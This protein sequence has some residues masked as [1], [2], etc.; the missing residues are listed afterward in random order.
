MALAKFD[1]LKAL[2]H[3]R[4]K[5]L[6][7]E[8]ISSQRCVRLLCGCNQYVNTTMAE[9]LKCTESV[10]P[11][12]IRRLY[13]TVWHYSMPHDPSL[14]D[15]NTHPGLLPVPGQVGDVGQRRMGYTT[16][17]VW[18]GRGPQRQNQDR[19]GRIVN[20]GMAT[21]SIPGQTE[22]SNGPRTDSGDRETTTLL[23][24]ENKQGGRTG[25][26]GGRPCLGAKIADLLP[27]A[28]TRRDSFIFGLSA[29]DNLRQHLDGPGNVA[30]TEL[31]SRLWNVRTNTL[32][33]S[34][35][36][37][38]TYCAVSYVWGQWKKPEQKGD[39]NPGH[40]PDL[41][42]IRISLL[43]VADDTDIDLF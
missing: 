42:R 32:L 35:P 29:V 39:E 41:E 5:T 2:G 10:N 14:S 18:M 30:P 38:T 1:H 7:H 21:R 33:D 9:F 16:A 19:R 43:E 36:S 17:R 27:P 40:L 28:L 6:K 26:L 12:L 23:P 4:N 8:A 24:Y 34:F 37:G 20:L 25:H 31:P 3:F 13:Q 22:H 15:K 11:E